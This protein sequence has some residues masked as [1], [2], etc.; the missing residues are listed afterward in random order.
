MSKNLRCCLNNM[1]ALTKTENKKLKKSLLNDMSCEE[2][3]FRA[4][5]E[6]VWNFYKKKIKLTALDKKI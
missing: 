1:N 4:L 3:Y 6:I 2:Y 5:Y